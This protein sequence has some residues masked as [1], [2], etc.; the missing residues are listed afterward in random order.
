MCILVALELQYNVSTIR[1][2][3]QKLMQQQ[4]IFGTSSGKLS[5]E[6]KEKETA[7]L[8]TTN[9]IP[10]AP[11]PALLIEVIN[12]IE[13]MFEGL[14]HNMPIYILIDNL[15]RVTGRVRDR[16]SGQERWDKEATLEKYSTNI[17]KEFMY[18]TNFRYHIISNHEN[19]HI[20]GNLNKTLH[21]LDPRTEFLYFFQHDFK[22]VTKVN[23]AAIIKTMRD[24]PGVVKNIRFNKMR[25]IPARHKRGKDACSNITDEVQN[26]NGIHL[27]RTD[28]WSDNNHFASVE[29][30]KWIMEKMIVS[31]IRRP[32]ESV[33]M[34]H[35]RNVNWTCNAQVAQHLYGAPYEPAYLEHLDGRLQY[36]VV[37][38]KTLNEAAVIGMTSNT[39]STEATRTAVNVTTNTG[40]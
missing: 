27:T 26:V 8:I 29:H 34:N 19:Q 15:P 38:N 25:N 40:E 31:S 23:H 33:M 18:R 30:Y 9:W 37:R 12:F 4:S 32:L 5:S 6:S 2:V 35:A 1:L 20:G 28:K 14:P 10:S 11:S 21:L 7:I 16:V 24:F 17:M 13:L 39:T 3:S 22:F 36:M